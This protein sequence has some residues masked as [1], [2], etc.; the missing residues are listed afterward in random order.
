MMRSS[1]GSSAADSTASALW[2]RIAKSLR[3]TIGTKSVVLLRYEL[4]AAVADCP[5]PCTLCQMQV[6]EALEQ[7]L[8]LEGARKRLERSPMIGVSP[9]V[10]IPQIS[11]DR[12]LSHVAATLARSFSRADSTRPESPRRLNDSRSLM[13][14]D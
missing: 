4:P 11:E 8:V 5:H 12:S 3:V 9:C 6:M 1:A 10:M 2:F 13:H 14:P 7:R